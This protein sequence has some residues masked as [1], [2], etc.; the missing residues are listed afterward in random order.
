MLSNQPLL[1]RTSFH[2]QSRSRETHKSTSPTITLMKGPTWCIQS[3]KCQILVIQSS[4]C[5]TISSLPCK[6]GNYPTKFTFLMY[7]CITR[8]E[9]VGIWNCL[10]YTRESLG[11]YFA[12]PWT[13][14][15]LQRFVQ[16][17][18]HSRILMHQNGSGAELTVVWR[19][20]FVVLATSETRKT[21]L[22][23]VKQPNTTLSNQYSSLFHLPPFTPL[24]YFISRSSSEEE[25]KQKIQ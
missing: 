12:R 6:C 2:I 21:C 18:G 16:V 9:K 7:Y 25:G 5:Y 4:P 8:N 24:R 11:G 15:P 10:T 19:G 17:S 23:Q 13:L 22:S 3:H 1:L 20:A 14:G